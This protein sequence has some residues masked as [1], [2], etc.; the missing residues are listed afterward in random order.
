MSTLMHA[1]RPMAWDFFSAIVFAVLT[2]LHV[3]PRLATVVALAAGVAQ[4]GV[5][6]V[7]RRPI[8]PLQWAGLGLT[9]VFGTASLIAHDPRLVMAKPSLIYAA[10]AAVML[11]RGWMLRY[12][13]SVARGHSEDLMVGWGYAWA[14]LMAATAAANL[15]VAVW[16]SPQW[17]MFV[18]VFPAASK[19]ALFA[20][21]Y[22][23]MRS[24]IRARIISARSATPQAA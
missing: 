18:G 11:K 17:P 13:P 4:V 12:V 9:V 3:D 1:L 8:E 23:S 22:V 21:Q 7:M 6:W 2:A 10:L 15:V 19:V 16:F 20:L 14:G 24:V 5:L